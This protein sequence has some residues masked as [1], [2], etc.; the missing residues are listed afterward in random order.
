MASFVGCHLIPTVGRKREIFITKKS[1][2]D[3]L[4]HYI[5]RFHMKK[6]RGA[7]VFFCL[8]FVCFC[9]KKSFIHSSSF[10]KFFSCFSEA[11]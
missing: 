7:C 4:L 9:E 10:K 3:K 11:I 8:D 2:L 5:E 6:M 1:I